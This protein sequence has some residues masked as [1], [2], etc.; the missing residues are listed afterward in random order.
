MG[1][2]GEVTGQQIAASVE[3]FVQSTFAWPWHVVGRAPC[4]AALRTCC[5]ARCRA[6]P[7]AL[8]ISAQNLTI[9]Q[10]YCQPPSSPRPARGPRRQVS[11]AQAA[12]FRGS[13]YRVQGWVAALRAWALPAAA[14]AAVLAV[15]AGGAAVAAGRRERR[16]Q[17]EEEGR[18]VAG[19]GGGDE[20]RGG[21][22]SADDEVSGVTA[23]AP[24]LLPGG[25][26]GGSADSGGRSNGGG[27][28]LSQPLLSEGQ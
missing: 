13:V 7:K 9:L 22:A 16:R 14:V 23:A 4:V 15:A 21:E 12:A 26:G 25:G 1:R 24:G 6:P 27:A 8:Y 3:Q 17:E 20:E 2:V 28:G 19:R 10:Y 5:P 18:P 11:E